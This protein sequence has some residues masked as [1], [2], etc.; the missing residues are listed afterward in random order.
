M[1]LKYSYGIVAD[2]LSG[3]TQ[4][5]HKCEH[6]INQIQSGDMTI[7][8]KIHVCVLHLCVYKDKKASEGLGINVLG[9][10]TDINIPRGRN[11][12]LNRSAM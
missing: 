2:L 4:G 6:W 1:W 12:A 5:K 10:Q 11:S 7:I 9:S 8:S 3:N